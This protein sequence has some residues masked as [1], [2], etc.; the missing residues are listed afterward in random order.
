M[1]PRDP[2]FLGCFASDEVQKIKLDQ[3][4]QTLIANYAPASSS[5]G[6]R[7]HWVAIGCLGGGKGW[8][9]GSYGLP[10]DAADIYLSDQTHFRAYL[11]AQFPR[12]WSSNRRDFQALGSAV[13]GLYAIWAC[14]HGPYQLRPGKWR[15]FGVNKS[16]NDR[17][18]QQLVHL[19]RN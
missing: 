4:G 2:M 15:M 19:P 11:N 16:A 17:K 8:F 1:R 18:I 6:E 13:C 5:G 14:L 3:A 12:G 7:G 9:F 10:P